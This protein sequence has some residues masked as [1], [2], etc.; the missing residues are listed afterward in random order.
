M[1]P[2]ASEQARELGIRMMAQQ[3]TGGMQA[4]ALW[5]DENPEVPRSVVLDTAMDFVWLGLARVRDGEHMLAGG[6]TVKRG[7]GR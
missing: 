2:A 3:L 6:K 7:G 4:L 1:V 5:W